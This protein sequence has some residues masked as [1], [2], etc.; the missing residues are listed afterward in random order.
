MNF[1]NESKSEENN[2]GGGGGGGGD[3][4]SLRLKINI[5]SGLFLCPCS[6]QNLKFLAQVVL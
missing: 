2:Y 5:G 3:E 1:D 6:I 4:G